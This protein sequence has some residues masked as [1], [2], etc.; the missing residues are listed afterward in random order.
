MTLIWSIDLSLRPYLLKI[1][2]DKLSLPKFSQNQDTLI[3]S[4]MLYLGVIL[5]VNLSYRAHNYLQLKLEPPLRREVANCVMSQLIQHSESFYQNH[6]KGEIINRVR[7][8]ITSIPEIIKIITNNFLTHILSISIALFAMYKINYK[9]TLGLIACVLFQILFTSKISKSVIQLGDC[10][11]N[12]RAQALGAILDAMYNL[13]NIKLFSGQK[14][15]LKRLSKIFKKTVIAEQKR[16]WFLIKV[17]TVQTLFFFIYQI[18]CF[19]YLIQGHKENKITPGD[20]IMIININI[21]LIDV[22][23]CIIDD[24]KIITNHISNVKEGVKIIFAPLL[25]TD[26][27]DAKNLN[28]IKGKIIFKDVIFKHADNKHLFNG[29]SV[30]IRA[31]E[32]VGLVGFSG[33]GKS[34][35]VNLIMRLYEPESGIISIDDQDIKNV[36]QNSLRQ[37]IAFISQEPN[38]FNASLLENIRYAKPLASIEEINRAAIEA[39]AYEFI[40]ELPNGYNTIVGDKG[41]KLSGGQRQRIAILRAILVDA[42]IN[43]FDEATSGLDAITENH[44]QEAMLKLMVN[45]TTLII[46]HRLSTLL[47]MDRILV[48]DKGKIVEDGSHYDLI[49]KDSLYKKLWETQKAGFI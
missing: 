9:F 41:V 38:L 32:R 17:F 44:I 40:N 12:N 8:I 46:A 26:A 4:V 19:Y 33:S 18:F 16:E 37:N 13:I 42:P 22:F 20:F 29:K 35:F 45:K 49:N 1:I 34:S 25:I 48:F 39:K 11:S 5:F 36:T 47:S 14:R 43:I 2:I 24:V 30:V 3:F 23:W 28:L 10:A 6:Q 7:E 15:A 31:K 21:N 27:V